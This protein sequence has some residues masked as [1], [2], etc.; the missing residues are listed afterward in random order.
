LSGNVSITG[1]TLEG[2]TGSVFA[3][4]ASNGQTVVTNFA[5]GSDGAFQDLPVGQGFAFAIAEAQVD[6]CGSSP[7]GSFSDSFGP[8]PV[9]HDFSI[10]VDTTPAGFIAGTLGIPTWHD[11]SDQLN[12][13]LVGVF[14]LDQGPPSTGM[15]N[16]AATFFAFSLSGEHAFE[17]RRWFPART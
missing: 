10:E 13:E 16:P 12:Y 7:G 17:P 1:G 8:D 11:S 6:G 9:Q 4:N 3:S 15:C 14:D 5:F 2:G